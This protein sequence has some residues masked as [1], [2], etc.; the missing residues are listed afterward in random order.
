MAFYLHDDVS[1]GPPALV[2]PAAY[3][4]A[5]S[6]DATDDSDLS[7]L[8]AQDVIVDGTDLEQAYQDGLRTISRG[9]SILLLAVYIV[10]LWFQV[11][12]T[13]HEVVLSLTRALISFA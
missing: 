5:K 7:R 6:P 3:H 2:I 11:C 12:L 8:I 4:S 1:D 10:Y 9:T 13:L